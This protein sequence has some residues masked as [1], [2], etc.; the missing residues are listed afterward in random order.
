MQFLLPLT[1]E[2]KKCKYSAENCPKTL[3]TQKSKDFFKKLKIELN[4]FC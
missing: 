2:I 4:Y 3:E 1:N